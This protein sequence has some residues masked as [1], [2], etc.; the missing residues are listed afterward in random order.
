LNHARDARAQT[1]TAKDVTW[2]VKD[3]TRH[4]K[5]S[6]RSAKDVTRSVKDAT[7]SVKDVTRSVKDS[8]WSAKFSTPNHEKSSIFQ[9]ETSNPTR[10][11]ADFAAVVSKSAGVSGEG[12][13]SQDLGL[14]QAAEKL[15]TIHEIT[16]SS[17]KRNSQFEL[18]RVLSWIVLLLPGNGCPFFCSLLEPRLGATVRDT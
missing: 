1:G 17:T 11:G 16:R 18:F 5:D 10:K 4:V 6:T 13:P 9:P 12:R 8:M 15:R 2:T 7:R 14:G 3:P